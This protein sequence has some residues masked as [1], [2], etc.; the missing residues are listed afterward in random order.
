[1][2]EKKT[3]NSLYSFCPQV[4]YPGGQIV[5]IFIKQPIA[6]YF[7]S[8]FGSDNVMNCFHMWRGVDVHD[9]NSN[10]FIEQQN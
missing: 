7:T 8:E 10:M 9:A 5:A 6:H 1:M 4:S 3:G 2:Q